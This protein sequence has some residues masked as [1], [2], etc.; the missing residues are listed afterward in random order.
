MY[1]RDG[2]FMSMLNKNQEKKPIP[3]SKF[4]ED[5]IPVKGIENGMIIGALA[6]ERIDR[7][8][9]SISVTAQ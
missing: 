9:H 8:K 6:A 2:V 4:T 3:T 1:G 5:W 7:K